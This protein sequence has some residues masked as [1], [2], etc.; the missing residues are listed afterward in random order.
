MNDTSAYILGRTCSLRNQ[1]ALF[2]YKEGGYSMRCKAFTG[3]LLSSLLFISVVILSCA[4]YTSR[5]TFEDPPRVGFVAEV[6]EPA[7]RGKLTRITPP[8]MHVTG[9]YAVSPDGKS[10]V[11]SGKQSG[12]YQP[13]QLYRLDIGT[14]A[15]VKITSG[16]DQDCW[17][18]SFTG[19]GEY[20]V[21]RGGNTFWKIKKNGCFLKGL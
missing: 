20:I 21:Y 1:S 10:V 5:S 6:D 13:Y 11:F 4:T 12:S 2:N 17:S 3:R 15:P 7:T 8:D 9:K 19:D 16:G 18:P 14:S